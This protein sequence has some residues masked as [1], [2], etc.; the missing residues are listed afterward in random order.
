MNNIKSII[1]SA[2]E[3]L[4]KRYFEKTDHS[5]KEKYHLLSEVDVEMHNYLSTELKILYPNHVIDSEENEIDNSSNKRK[6]IIDP[7]DG[8]T[9]F[10]CGKPYFTISV[11]IEENQEIIEGYVYNPISEEFFVSNTKANKSFLNGEEIKVSEERLDNSIFVLGLSFNPTKYNEYMSEWESVLLKTK[12]CLF[13]TAPAQTI[14]NIA[15]GRLNCFID[16]GYS[17]HGQSAASLILKNAGGYLTNY[18]GTEYSHNLEGIIATSP[19][20]YEEIEKLNPSKLD[21]FCY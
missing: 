13:W 4:K 18:D 7:I 12:K 6:L 14:C 10:I 5:I 21:A 17:T 8:T 1:I 16:M 19:N 3:I 11:A 9:N 20:L 2:G 15:C